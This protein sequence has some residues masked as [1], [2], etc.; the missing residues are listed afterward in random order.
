[1]NT[2]I[3]QKPLTDRELYLQLR[4]AVMLAQTI[5]QNKLME[6]E[7]LREMFNKAKDKSDRQHAAIIRDKAMAAQDL[8]TEF[9]G[10]ELAYHAMEKLFA[11]NRNVLPEAWSR[12]RG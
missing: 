8:A 10:Q 3:E 5:R 7:A 2:D 12:S 6:I 4:D 11:L 9:A 1:M